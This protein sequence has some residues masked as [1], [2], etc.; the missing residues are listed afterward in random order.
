MD[1]LDDMRRAMVE[2][3]DE[4]GGPVLYTHNSSEGSYN[5]STGEYTAT[6]QTFNLKGILM[7]MPLHRNGMQVKAGTMIQDGDKLLFVVPAPGMLE[8]PY[9]TSME[10]V[11]ADTVKTG[12]TVW[13][14]YNVKTADPDGSG[15]IVY[16]FYLRR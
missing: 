7:D 3:M 15:P 5:P 2:L 9:L 8:V 11:S 10:N 12:T 14:V 6:V 13:R 1:S 4:L 16:E